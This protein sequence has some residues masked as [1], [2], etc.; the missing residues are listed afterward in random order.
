MTLLSQ[1]TTT[2]TLTSVVESEVQDGPRK[3][4][5]DAGMRQLFSNQPPLTL[6]S[7]STT[8]GTI[9]SVVKPEVLDG[10]KKTAIDATNPPGVSGNQLVLSG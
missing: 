1:S 4:S 8:T 3:A 5:L 9:A 2:G 6:L 7:Q 10:P